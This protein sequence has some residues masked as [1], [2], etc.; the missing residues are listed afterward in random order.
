MF[1]F[2]GVSGRNELQIIMKKFL[3]FLFAAALFCGCDKDDAPCPVTSVEFPASSAE[4]PVQPG[5]S[6]TIRGAGFTEDSEIW[7]RGTA[8]TTDVRA[9]VTNVSASAVTFIAPNVSGE[10]TVLLKQNGGEWALGKMYFAEEPDLDDLE[11]LPRKVMRMRLVYQGKYQEFETAYL[12]DDRGNIIGMTETEMQGETVCGTYEYRS[13]ADAITMT[14]KSEMDPDY[15]DIRTYRLTDGRVS[16]YTWKYEDAAKEYNSETT[17]GITYDA[18]GYVQA[19]NIE[20]NYTNSDNET[21]IVHS[22]FGMEVFGGTL[23][24]MDFK[25]DYEKYAME[26]T[27]KQPNNLNIDLFGIILS[28]YYDEVSFQPMTMNAAGARLRT[29]PE[30]V[31]IVET[32]EDEEE[33]GTATTRYLFEYEMDGD[34]ISKITVSAPDDEYFEESHG[35]FATIELF[36][37]E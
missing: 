13:T 15:T 17:A 19:I 21:G 27:P 29:L 12:Y 32:W 11:L 25:S 2:F 5:T 23:V 24:G 26:L 4:N 20:E 28:L 14:W 30:Q 33:Q 34:Y 16:S 8:R 3:F 37:E 10:Q 7:L 9:T 18:K 1:V 36:Y 35:V 6:V 22:Q 31:Q